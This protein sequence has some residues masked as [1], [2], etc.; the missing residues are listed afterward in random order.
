MS[1]RS[2]KRAKATRD[3]R[4]AEF[5]KLSTEDKLSRKRPGSLNPKK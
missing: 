5:D 3:S 2:H 1:K 4:R